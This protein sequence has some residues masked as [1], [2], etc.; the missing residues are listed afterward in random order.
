MIKMEILKSLGPQKLKFYSLVFIFLNLF[1]SQMA[2][3]DGSV[4]SSLD[5]NSGN[6]P[7]AIFQL[8]MSVGMET[9]YVIK[10]VLLISGI[11]GLIFIILGLLKIRANALDSQS[12]GSHLK[13][14]IILVILGGLLFGAPTL[15]EMSG[16]SLFGSAPSPVTTNGT[17]NCQ[18]VNG[19]YTQGC[20][21]VCPGNSVGNPDQACQACSDGT[22]ATPSG[23]LT[24]NGVYGTGNEYCV[25]GDGTYV[26]DGNCVTTCPSG[27]HNGGSCVPT[28]PSG[29]NDGGSCVPSCPSGLND[30]GSCVTTC[31]SGA[32]LNNNGTCAATCPSG[33]PLNNNGTC[34]TTC[35]SGLNDSGTCVT[36][37]PSGAPLNN[38]GTCAATCPSGAPLN[39]NGTCATTCPSGLNDSGTCVTTCPSGLSDNGTC[40]ANCPS[41]APFNNGGTCAS[42]CPANDISSSNVCTPC[43]SGQSPQSNV[44]YCDTAGQGIDT[45]SGICETCPNT[46]STPDGTPEQWVSSPPFCTVYVKYEVSQLATDSG[47][48]MTS[49]TMAPGVSDGQTDI[50]CSCSNGFSAVYDLGHQPPWTIGF[51]DN[52]SM[53]LNT[54]ADFQTILTRIETACT[55]KSNSGIYPSK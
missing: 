51:D 30:G 23:C 38:N 17:V 47:G 1:L 53:G 10:V 11:L 5:P 49:C 19:Q 7:W 55:S 8:M 44:C 34:A 48:V 54:E 50:T 12:G 40:V 45:V 25:C 27:L 42:S 31:P 14:G 2:F 46:G 52:A 9:W 39:N 21:L 33:A 22:Y 18:M 35:P 16:Y 3:A 37:C 43:P 26:S 4:G 36:T 13:H 29:L 24:C 41:G 32:P 15:M 20:G 28:C 6:D